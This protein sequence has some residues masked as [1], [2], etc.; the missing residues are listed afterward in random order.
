M[1]HHPVFRNFTR[2]VGAV[3][4]GFRVDFIGAK[5]RQEFLDGNQEMQASQVKTEYPE[6]NEEY[7]EWI[8]VLESVVAAQGHY[9]V[10]ELGAGFGR[11][12]VRAA[13]ATRQYSGLPFSLIAAEPEPIHFRWLKTH[14]E[15]NGI[16]PVQHVLEQAAV[17]DESGEALFYVGMP[18]GGPD[19]ANQWYG[20]ALVK[21]YEL[22]DDSAC[23]THDGHQVVKLVSG[24]KSIR[25]P[26]RTLPDLMSDVEIVDLVD[27]DLQGQELKVIVSSVDFLNRVA[28]RLHIGTH[29]HE[30]EDELRSL[31]QRNSWECLADYRCLSEN[32]TP[33]GKVQFVD[34]VQSWVNTRLA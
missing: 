17:S 3:D 4:A 16:D 5:I 20:Q 23:G 13:L 31:L 32:D 26:K 30:L 11:W 6:L 8:D 1:V 15:D 7:F 33:Y 34:G 19:R 10:A 21:D 9:T 2:Y 27:F 22:A 14:L 12:S 29:S 24:W 28:R 25:V 18:D